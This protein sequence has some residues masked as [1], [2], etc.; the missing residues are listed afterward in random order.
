MALAVGTSSLQASVFVTPA[1]SDPADVAGGSNSF[2]TFGTGAGIFLLTSGVMFDGDN[3][4]AREV[5]PGTSGLFGKTV[6]V[7]GKSTTF[8]GAVIAAL[9]I[10]L[11][12]TGGTGALTQCVLVQGPDGF[13]F[14]A[15]ASAVAE[16]PG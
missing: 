14:I 6:Q 4:L 3:L 7:T 8:R 15:L 2:I 1:L 12:T 13:R 16:V 5:A 10:E 9:G 11:E